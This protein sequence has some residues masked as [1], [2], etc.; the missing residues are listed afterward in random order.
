MVR[1]LYGNKQI[2]KANKMDIYKI[3]STKFDELRRCDWT[4]VMEK[5]NG[6]ESQMF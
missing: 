3:Y 4:L 6:S 2:W 5:N 1:F